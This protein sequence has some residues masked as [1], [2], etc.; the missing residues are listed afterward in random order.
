MRCDPKAVTVVERAAKALWRRPRVLEDVL[1]R[2]LGHESW[3]PDTRE[4]T[5]ATIAEL[6]HLYRKRLKSPPRAR[7]LQHL[8]EA[9]AL[10][11]GPSAPPP[12]PPPS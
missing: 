7:A 4:A 11:A 2:R 10:K 1:W 8:A 9:L 5:L 6:A 3:G 12:T